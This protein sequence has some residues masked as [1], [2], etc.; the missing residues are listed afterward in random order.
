MLAHHK[1]TSAKLLN[2]LKDPAVVRNMTEICEKTFD[3]KIKCSFERYN[4]MPIQTERALV[5]FLFH[6]TPMA[7]NFYK[8]EYADEELV[9]NDS[10]LHTKRVLEG[11]E[12]RKYFD[13][14]L[15]ICK[16]SALIGYKIIYIYLISNLEY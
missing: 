14:L 1:I 2:D 16:L 7:S 11:I 10:K 9:E 4:K 3:V 15:S 5:V 12:V 6:Q 13:C 8:D